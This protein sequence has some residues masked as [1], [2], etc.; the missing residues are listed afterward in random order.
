MAFPPIP[1][2]SRLLSMV[3]H[4]IRNP[5]NVISLTVRV[6][7]QV[8]PLIREELKEDLTFLRDNATHMEVMLSLLSDLCRL[9][10]AGTSYEA[11]PFEGGRFIEEMLFER[12]Q[13]GNEPAYPA[14]FDCDPTSP[15]VVFLDPTLAR[16]AF[17]AVLI[18][19]AG[20][21]DRPLNVRSWGEGDRWLIAVSVEKPPPRTVT[22]Q[23]VQPN[24]FQRLLGS[25]AERRGL[26][27]SIASWISAQFGGTIRLNVVPDAQSTI[28]I[29]WP[30]NAS[31]LRK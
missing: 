10:E 5:L 30:V 1:I 26:D 15:S 31:A 22:S 16:L 3:V 20:A 14:K 12:A 13:K 7:E 28:V 29:D 25:A 17:Q 2:D 9:N 4:D 24:D 19:A 6:I 8:S 27:L 11:I 23:D 18:N 21:T